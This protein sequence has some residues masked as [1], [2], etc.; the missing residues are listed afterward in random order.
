MT[1][2][3]HLDRVVCGPRAK[4]G[5]K[6]EITVSGN[7]PADLNEREAQAQARLTEREPMIGAQPNKTA[8]AGTSA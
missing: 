1:S 2:K 7:V 8:D 4:A 3:A 6:Y 5:H